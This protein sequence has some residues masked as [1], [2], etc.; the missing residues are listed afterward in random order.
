MSNYLH[1]PRYIR[2]NG[3]PLI[4]VY[5]PSLLPAPKQTSERWRAWCKE[6]EIGE[7][8]LAYT[9]SFENANPAQYGFDAAIEF[10]PNMSRPPVISDSIKPLHDNFSCTV[11]DWQALAV[12]SEKYT[13][14]EYK[15]FRS[16]C[17]GWDNTPRRKNNSTVFI[18]NTPGLY[19]HWLENAITDTKQRYSNPEEQMVFI[20]AWNEWAEGAY[21][22]PDD[23]NGYAYLKATRDALESNS[24]TRRIV[25]V[26]H[27]AHPHG[28]QTLLLYILKMLVNELGFQVDLVLLGEGPLIS[29]YQSYAKVHLL[30]GNRDI[31]EDGIQ[32]AN[33]L[34]AQGISS[35]IANTTVTGHFVVSLKK[36]GFTVVSLIHE[37]PGVIQKYQLESH[38]KAIADSADHVVFPA[39]QVLN[40]F[41]SFVDLPE[42]KIAIRPQG[43]FR[44][45]KYRS[46]SDI[47]STRIWLRNKYH[48]PES[49]KIILS[50]GYADHRKGVDLF[51]EAGISLIRS[52]D[53]VYFIW[54]GHFDSNIEPSIRKKVE[55]SEYADRFIFPGLDF[56][57]DRYYAGSDVYALTS[58]ED[59]FP[60]VVLEA[61][62]VALPVVAFEGA[63]GFC[64]LLSRGGGTIVPAFE[65]DKYTSA[66]SDLLKD[67]KLAQRQGEN[68]R[69]IVKEEFSFRKYVFDIAVLT[70]VDLQR[71]SAIIPNYNYEDYLTVRLN[72]VA[73]QL[74]PIYEI[75][76]LDD[77]SSDGSKELIKEFVDNSQIDCKTV[78]N[79]R[80]SG[81]PFR[82]WLS[83]L[84]LVQGDLV[85]IAEADDMASTEFL[86]EVIKPFVDDEVVL[87]YCQSKQINS[88]GH[89]L[90][91]SY[92][93]YLSDI[94][95]TKWN[96][97]YIQNGIDEITETLGIKNTI[98]NVSAV[99]FNREP[100]YNVL[101][102]NIEEISSYRVAG[103]WLTYVYVLG[104]GKIAFTPLALNYHRRHLDSVTISSFGISQ[105]KEILEV[106]QRVRD[107]YDIPTSIQLKANGYVQR[108]Y[109]E[110]NLQLSMATKWYEH[111]ELSHFS[112][113]V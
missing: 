19:R 59:P 58:R 11:Y 10:P 35:A 79:K 43:I 21:L 38:V 32:L 25:L 3:R 80:N 39:Q 106:Q 61:L 107:L 112:K 83:G 91:E 92:H 47:D 102:R 48:L 29:E 36:A 105:L 64:E 13:Q 113:A 77:H 33:L 57:T 6:N 87:S 16:V 85:W 110:F 71:V 84:E 8:Y 44:P 88:D 60:S 67:K 78:F 99:L 66:I 95:L 15:L 55:E 45:N 14:P 22:E 90:A 73:D 104:K 74:Y 26:G 62:D 53:D 56:D 108:L 1:D 23:Q 82:Q 20:N 54:V 51:V 109:K 103:D 96:N 4:I 93:E 46:E 12:R 40:G 86:D 30:Y 111:P 52:L 27:D 65:M 101:S 17:P 18:N 7:I 41:M 69:K 5:R 98:P 63:G 2:V 24:A 37:L 94:S 72:S 50:I 34:Y 100:L 97:Q 70:N 75:I 89:V 42:S 81:S 28:A 76:I 31:K 49:A 9:Q 68:G